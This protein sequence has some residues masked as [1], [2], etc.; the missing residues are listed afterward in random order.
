MIWDVR[1]LRQLT[2]GGNNCT[3]NVPVSTIRV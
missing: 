2:E 3:G 1:H